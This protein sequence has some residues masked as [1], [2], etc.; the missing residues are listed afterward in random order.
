MTEKSSRPTRSRPRIDSLIVALRKE[1]GELAT[2]KPSD[3]PDVEDVRVRCRRCGG[4]TVFPCWGNEPRPTPAP[5]AHC[6]EVI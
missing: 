2:G 4:V 1:K 5:C 6:G 3:P